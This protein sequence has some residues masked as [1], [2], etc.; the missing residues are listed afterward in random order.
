MKFRRYLKWKC[1]VQKMINGQ[2]IE[3]YYFLLTEKLFRA[4]AKLEFGIF[5]SSKL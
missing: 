4:Y 3:G 2:D 1:I 5:A